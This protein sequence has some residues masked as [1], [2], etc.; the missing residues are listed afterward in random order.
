MELGSNIFTPSLPF[1]LLLGLTIIFLF[2]LFRMMRQLE[3]LPAKFAVLAIWLRF[4]FSA[5]HQITFAPMIGGLSPN[6]LLSVGA[7]LAGIGIISRSTFSQRWVMPI[8]F[9]IFIILISGL[10]NRALGGMIDMIFK[11]GYVI[12]LIA[13]IH[14]AILTM[15]RERFFRVLLK[16]FVPVLT[17]QL[18]SIILGLPK[19]GENDGSASYI[20]G[21]SHE[22][23]FSIMG[24]GFMMVVYFCRDLA[25]SRRVALMSLGIVSI[26]FANY[27]TTILS[28]AP[29]LVG[30]FALGSVVQFVPRQRLVVAMLL[31]PIGVM[32]ASF[33]VDSL[34]QRF[35]D[36]STVVLR[37][38]ELLKPAYEYT[39]SEQELFSGR[40]FIWA[41]YISSYLHGSDMQLLFG[42][43]PS[44][45]VGIFNKYAHNTVIS[46]LYELGVFGAVAIISIWVTFLR[47]ALQLRD[48][49]VRIQMLLAQIG[50]L[51]LNF[52]TMPHWL[53]EGNIVFAIM[54]GCLLAELSLQRQGSL[55]RTDRLAAPVPAPISPRGLNGSL[56]F[57]SEARD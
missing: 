4:M 36:F 2:L 26:L 9:L 37:G 48:P 40:L 53:I 32:G 22:A 44:K 12:V 6:A 13:A 8:Y 39:R 5:Y 43:G 7:V 19:A 16:C 23:A 27:R 10:G 45:W 35:L 29:I 51:I 41:G 21:Y 50:F 25:F 30:F 28:T 3:G 49:L 18:S 20:G 57:S 46:L 33:A 38:E 56:R 34:Q 55:A 11:W 52:A 42:L 14:E 1:P 15:G 47:G 54:Q 31:V 17:L 24:L